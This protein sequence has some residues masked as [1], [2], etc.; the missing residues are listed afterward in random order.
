M[1]MGGMG[2]GG[3]GMGGGGYGSGGQGGQGGQGGYGGR[4]GSYDMSQLTQLIEN[5]IAPDSWYD[6]SDYGE[7]VISAYPP[8]MGMTLPKKLAITNTREVHQQVEHLLDELRKSLLPQVSIEARFLTVSKNF[9]E[10]I[11]L[12]ADMFLNKLGGKWGRMTI[13]Q[14]SA[15]GAKATSTEV[16]GSLGNIPAAVMASGAYGSSILNPLQVEY[17]LRA[18]QARS[19]T[20]TLS[21]PRV[22]VMSGDPA[23]FS[24]SSSFQFAL[25]PQ[26]QQNY[27]GGTTLGTNQN[28]TTLT[29]QYSTV[30]TGNALQI[31]PTISKDKKHV[32]LT[33]DL[34]RN[35]LVGIR[36][37]NVETVVFDAAGV[38]STVSY[39]VD[40]PETESALLSTR[41]SVPDQ[42]TL[43]LGG[44]T[45]TTEVEKQVGVPILSKIPLIGRV[46]SADSTVKDQQILLLLVKPIIILQNERD[47][48]AIA[49]AEAKE[50]HA[51]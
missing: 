2:M 38:G 18:T 8:S 9:M 15:S 37:Q 33:I 35:R 49:E 21:S 20:K 1:G 32:L 23:T 40:L 51:F 27:V 45:V 41:V 7:G 30:L 13:A 48:E 16:P 43:L 17:L 42:G 4:G 26:T 24:L 10:E 22:T 19:D 46:F 34:I 29:P 47:E 39:K 31:T 50:A 44:Q 36:S 3:M 11:G 25:P 14:D 5:T 12:D 6:T 28:Q